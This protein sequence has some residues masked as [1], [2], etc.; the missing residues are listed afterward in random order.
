MHID[1]H[2]SK[3]EYFNYDNVKLFKNKFPLQYVE[4]TQKKNLI[5]MQNEFVFGT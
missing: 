1:T 5:C 2:F 4:R 3:L